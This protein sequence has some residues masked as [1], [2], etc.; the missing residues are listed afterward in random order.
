M[1]HQEN[2]Y[3]VSEGIPRKGDGIQRKRIIIAAARIF[4]RF[5]FF[6]SARSRIVTGEER[7]EE[8]LT[9]DDTIDSIEK[10]F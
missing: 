3:V 4:C 7:G 8:D 10:K 5:F 9:Q 2:L 1:F 6:F